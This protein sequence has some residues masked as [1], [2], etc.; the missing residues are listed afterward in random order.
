MSCLEITEQVTVQLVMSLIR[1]V[2]MSLMLL[3][4]VMAWLSP[5]Q[6]AEAFQGAPRAVKVMSGNSTSPSTASGSGLGELSAWINFQGLPRLLSIAVFAQIVHH[7]IPGILHSIR[8]KPRNGRRVFGAAFSVTTFFYCSLGAILVAFFRTHNIAVAQSVNQVW[9]TWEKSLPPSNLGAYVAAAIR[10]ILV[11]FPGIDVLSAFPLCAIT[12][13]QNLMS[14]RYASGEVQGQGRFTTI[15]FRLLAACP[16]ILGALLV[17]DIGAVNQWVGVF[18]FALVFL[19]PG[20]LGRAARKLTVEKFGRRK[21]ERTPYS[22]GVSPMV[23]SV[24]IVLGIIFPVF[25]FSSL[26]ACHA[27][28]TSM[29]FVA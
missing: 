29:C 9:S 24:L 19:F 15:L 7:S 17:S 6:G 25:F 2:C 22:V 5:D 12:L 11:I 21:G 27:G 26:G 18:G 10:Y 14:L 20:L 3:T 16:P 13:G 4:V 23:Y 1:V 28:I 8:D